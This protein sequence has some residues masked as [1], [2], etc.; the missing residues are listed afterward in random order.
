MDENDDDG[1][2]IGA[3]LGEQ[4]VYHFDRLHEFFHFNEA[5]RK[6][7]VAILKDMPSSTFSPFI[8]QKF[9]M[10]KI[11]SFISDTIESRQICNCADYEKR[12]H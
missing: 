3:Y 10:L 4:S 11:L 12:I 2:K 8:V 5:E 1:T 6:R 7:F 9:A